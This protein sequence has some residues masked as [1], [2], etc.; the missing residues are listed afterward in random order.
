VAE[1]IEEHSLKIPSDRGE[2][3][4]HAAWPGTSAPFPVVIVVHEIFGVNEH[5]QDLCR[6]LAR[7]GYYAVA[8]DL[9]ARQGDVSKMQDFREIIDKVASKISDNQIL[10]DLD[11]TVELARSSG[12]GDVSRLAITG[13]C[14]GGRIAWLYA[15]HSLRL[16]AAAAWYGRLTGGFQKGAKQPV[17]VAADLRCPVLGLYG[18]KDPSIPL[19][20]VEQMREALRSAG[21][22][23]CEIVVYP[24]AGHAFNADYRPTYHEASARDAWAR[25]LAWFKRHGAA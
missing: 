1:G 13:F 10:L 12:S 3:P 6:R 14:W 21:K 17:D 2:I 16:R 22:T 8:P 15:A 9:F 4:G 5:I 20:D 11:A 18:G 7:Q 23:D 25:M 19:Q 24:E